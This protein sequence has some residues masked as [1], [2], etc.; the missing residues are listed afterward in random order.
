MLSSEIRAKIRLTAPVLVFIGD[1][2][3]LPSVGA[4][5]VL[6]DLIASGFVPA[7]TL[8]TVFR[9]ASAS[10]I[11][12]HAHQINRGESPKIASPFNY[13]DLWKKS[14]CLFIDSDEPTQAQ[15]GFIAKVTRALRSARR[16][17]AP[18]HFR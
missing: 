7:Q 12:T 16:Q 10:A 2:D 13:P 15:L 4:G 3:Q 6:R 18:I 17:R 11:I 9:Q 5:N 1:A 14:D 8:N